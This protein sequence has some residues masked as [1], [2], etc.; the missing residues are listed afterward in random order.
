MMDGLY[1][2]NFSFSSIEYNFILAGFGYKAMKP[3]FKISVWGVAL[4]VPVTV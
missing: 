1:I 2:P 4:P 3:D